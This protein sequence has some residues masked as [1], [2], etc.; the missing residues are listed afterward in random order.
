MQLVICN[1]S[2]CEVN[3][4]YWKMFKSKLLNKKIIKFC[5]LYVLLQVLPIFTQIFITSI[6]NDGKI[7]FREIDT[8]AVLIFSGSAWLSLPTYI[9]RFNWTYRKGR[10]YRRL[11]TTVGIGIILLATYVKSID[12][13]IQMTEIQLD[14]KL[15]YFYLYLTSIVLLITA[16]ILLTVAHNR[17]L[18]K[19]SIQLLWTHQSQ[20]AGIYCAIEEGI[21][22]K[23]GLKVETVEPDLSSPLAIRGFDASKYEFSVRAGLDVVRMQLNDQKVRSVLPIVKTNPFTMIVRAN[24]EGINKIEDLKGKKIAIQEGYETEIYIKE[25]LRLHGLDENDVLFVQTGMDLEPFYNDEVDV[26]LGYKGH[27]P[28]KIKNMNIDIK[29]F[30]FNNDLGMPGFGDTLVTTENIIKT[31]RPLVRKMVDSIIDGWEFAD[32]NR[33]DALKHVM[34][35]ARESI[36]FEKNSLDCMVDL[37]LYQKSNFHLL[38]EK[39][40]WLEVLQLLE[41]QNMLEEK[42]IDPSKLYINI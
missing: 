34:K 6:F 1:D 32:K 41:N 37:V 20:F 16:I 28:L 42:I 26:W 15:F 5:S 35:Y 30:E 17:L 36:D 4:K 29:Q 3:S 19:V 31:R 25:I 22:E 40:D 13:T 9:D 38:Q 23:N 8:I 12:L 21:F 10:F 2:H 11:A 39:E 24:K 33:E 7:N 27:E 14:S 18:K